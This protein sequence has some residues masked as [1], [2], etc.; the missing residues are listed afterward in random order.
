MEVNSSFEKIEKFNKKSGTIFLKEFKATFS[1]MVYELKLKYGI[2]YIK[3][4]AFKQLAHY[5]HYEALD[6]YEQHFPRILGITEM[7]NPPYAI[8][9]AIASQTTLQVTIAHHGTMPNNPDPVPTAIDLSPQ[10]FIVATT[11]IL[12]IINAPTFVDPVGEFF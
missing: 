5:V 3:A 11:N 12:L 4:F 6:V 1:I 9:I 7:P 2:N 10:Q 8:T